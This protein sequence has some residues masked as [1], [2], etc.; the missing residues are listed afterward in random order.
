VC[1]EEKILNGTADVETEGAEIELNINVNINGQ[2]EKEIHIPLSIDSSAEKQ[3]DS[4]VSSRLFRPNPC[5]G[6]IC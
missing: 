3:N 6:F 4:K 2:P 1:E 5:V